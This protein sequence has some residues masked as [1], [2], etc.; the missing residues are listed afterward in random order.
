MSADNWTICPKC[1]KEKDGK[2]EKLLQ[3]VAISYGKVSEEMY[4][5]LKNKTVNE[6][7]YSTTS[8]YTFREDYEIGVYENEFTVDYNGSCSKCNFEYSYSHREII[9]EMD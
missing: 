7:R 8:D 2:A 9:N 6:I 3:Q 5:R 4:N 1:K